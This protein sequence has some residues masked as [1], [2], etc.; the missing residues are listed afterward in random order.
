M[1]SLV[2]KPF[3]ST[4]RSDDDS[5]YEFSDQDINKLL[6]VTQTPPPT[7]PQKHEGFDRTGDWTTRV[8]MTQELGKAIN[9]G[10]YYYEQDLWNEHEWVRSQE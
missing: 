5:D 3:S 6:I 7:R 9:D 1:S 8:K 2:L 4:S 10:L